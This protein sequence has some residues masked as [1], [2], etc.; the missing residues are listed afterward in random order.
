MKPS[1]LYRGHRFPPAI[2]SLA[3]RWYFRF[4]LS[5]R[6]IGELLLERGIFVSDESIR[7]WCDKFEARLHPT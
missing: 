6:D 5:F 2:I 1:A 3:V 4:S 7:R